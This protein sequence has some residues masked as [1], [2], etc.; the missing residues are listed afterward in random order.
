M[1]ESRCSTRPT[2]ATRMGKAALASIAIATATLVAGCSGITS[3][4]DAWSRGQI[5][6]VE[7][8]TTA[9]PTPEW[10][11][12]DASDLTSQVCGSE[13]NCVQAVGNDY[14]TLLKFADVD[15]ARD[16]AETLGLDG[17]QIDPL[18]IHFSDT[19]LSPEARDEI[20]YTVSN[21][22]ASSAD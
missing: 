9:S 6:L 21:I 18:V 13:V 17:V 15:A 12:L 19:E 2:Y 22:N 4:M 8:F 10:P 14:L 1:S 5:D 11:Y 16:Y 7:R 3:A 20:V